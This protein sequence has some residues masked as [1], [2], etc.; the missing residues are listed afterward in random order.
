MNIP[1][2]LF[3]Y[4]RPKHTEK[5]LESLS[6]NINAD[7]IEL[8]IFCDVARNIEKMA[9][10]NEVSKVVSQER[11]K[12]EFK[13]VKIIRREENYGLYK[14]VTSGANFMFEKYDECIFL[15]D[16]LETSKYFY[17]KMCKVLIKYRN[18]NNVW[19]VSGFTP[20]FKNKEICNDLF[21]LKRANSWGWAT[22]KKNWNLVNWK[23]EPLK[24]TNSIYKKLNGAGNDLK[25]LVNLYNKGEIDSWATRWC[26][27]AIMNEKKT[28]YFKN[29]LVKN[30]GLDDTGTHSRKG[31]AT[32][33]FIV[34]I[35]D[36][37]LNES[38]FE[39]IFYKEDINKNFNRNF[40][41][42]IFSKIKWKLNVIKWR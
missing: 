41:D 17:E 3:V 32:N 37:E 34:E 1:V 4:N 40:N 38:D 16:D 35:N 13:E 18:S 21:F 2:A 33:K 9:N 15:E 23:K 28:I 22:W 31:S 26:Y 25:Y 27:Y 8:F 42:S 11:W 39:N 19:G 14:N 10:V 30:I 6:K 7:K 29:T 12:N 24:L 20:N 36:Y 5:T